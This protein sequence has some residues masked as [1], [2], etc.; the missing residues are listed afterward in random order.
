[1]KEQFVTYE[2]ALALKEL[3]F[4]EACFAVFDR[5]GELTG[6]DFIDKL[7]EGG[8]EKGV[9]YLFTAQHGKSITLITNK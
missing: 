6:I 9:I 8:L 3:G 4:N 7:M 2:I 5:K 1:M